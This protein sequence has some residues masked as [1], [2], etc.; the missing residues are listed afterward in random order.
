MNT[1]DTLTTR[2]PDPKHRLGDPA[3]RGSNEGR[4]PLFAP[5]RSWFGRT[6]GLQRRGQPSHTAPE[7]R[8][9]ASPKAH[10]E[11]GR[12]TALRHDHRRLAQLLDR[13]IQL[14]QRLRHLT[15]VEQTLAR[16][17]PRGLRALPEKVLRKAYEQLAGLQRDDP[18]FVVPELSRRLMSIF[19]S[20][21]E[22]TTEFSSTKAMQVSE[23]SH[24]LFD[25]MERSWNGKVPAAT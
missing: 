22:H 2:S 19:E 5:L 12:G 20:M 7:V 10:A 15:C 23:A 16:H 21:R 17:G 25:E 11:P 6:L 14:R 1:S 3:R 18:G 9:A 8:S 4:A 24:S 13:Q